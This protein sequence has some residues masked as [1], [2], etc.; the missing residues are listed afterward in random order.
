MRKLATVAAS[1][2]TAG[3]AAAMNL[4]LGAC[5]ARLQANG[6][7]PCSALVP[8]SDSALWALSE[9]PA[10]V[11]TPGPGLV[12]LVVAPIDDPG[13]AKRIEAVLVEYG[14]IDAPHRIGTDCVRAWP[15]Q[16][17]RSVAEYRSA[18]ETVTLHGIRPHA[19][20]ASGAIP[21][22]GTW[23]RG[24][25]LDVPFTELPQFEESKAARLFEA[26]WKARSELTEEHVP[27]PKPSVLGWIGVER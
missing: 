14:L 9:H 7:T 20:I 15:L 12:T 25:L 17:V 10:A 11:K 19:G 6:Y 23:P 1:I 8:D 13:L 22:D 24:S 5:A 27:P 26:I 4:T 2:A 18:F 16:S 21:L 3:P